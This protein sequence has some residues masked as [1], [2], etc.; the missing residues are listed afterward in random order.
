MPR[1]N[2]IQPKSIDALKADLLRVKL[3]VE[4]VKLRVL[5]YGTS[6]RCL[7]AF[8]PLPEDTFVQRRLPVILNPERN[9]DDKRRLDREAAND[10]KLAKTKPKDTHMIASPD[11]ELSLAELAADMQKYD[12]KL[13]ET[14]AKVDATMRTLRH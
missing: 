5:E 14:L 4:R 3:R 8:T 10:P 7:A 1:R 12:P 9:S 2:H 6:P 13:A 11:A